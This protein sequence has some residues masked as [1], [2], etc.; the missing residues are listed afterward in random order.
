MKKPNTLAL[1]YV[2]LINNYCCLWRKWK[3][4]YIRRKNLQTLWQCSRKDDAHD[5]GMPRR[6]GWNCW[7]KTG[8]GCNG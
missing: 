7:R 3:F 1:G 5:G 4:L 6:T 2:N 8:E